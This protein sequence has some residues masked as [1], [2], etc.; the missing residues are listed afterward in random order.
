MPHD[1]DA[2]NAGFAGQ[3]LEQYLENPSSV[4]EEWR[5]LFEAADD[6]QVLRLQPGL[7]RLL[8]RRT[9]GAPT[10]PAPADAVAAAPPA[11]PGEEL[12]G[13]VAAA[14][15]RRASTR[16]APSRRAI[17]RSRPSGWSPS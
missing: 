16:W 12:L 9:N 8:E 15:W 13:G 5:S 10:A 14:T 1:V 6:G 4:P 17:P 11:E 7:V 2:L 3:L